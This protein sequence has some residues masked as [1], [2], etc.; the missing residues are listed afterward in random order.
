MI[1]TCQMPK[2]EFVANLTL[3]LF[4]LIDKPTITAIDTSK[5]ARIPSQTVLQVS[6]PQATP[7]IKS[8]S[9]Y[10]NSQLLY[11]DEKLKYSGGTIGIPSLTIIHVAKDDDGNYKC[12]VNN[13]VDTSFVE[14]YLFTWSKCFYSN[15]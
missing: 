14:I 3:V 13:G 5:L 15:I 10:K 9:W 7:P 6:V 12:E 11:V 8:L 2:S 4:V 1:T